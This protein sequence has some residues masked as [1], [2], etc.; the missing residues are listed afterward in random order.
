MKYY[1]NEYM[2]YYADEY[3]EGSVLIWPHPWPLLLLPYPN[4]VFFDMQCG[5]LACYQRH[6]EGFYLPVFGQ[7]GQAFAHSL[8][9]LHPGCNGP[10]VTEEQAGALDAIF[11]EF[12]VPLKVVRSRLDYSYEAWVHVEVLAPNEDWLLSN[13]EGYEGILIWRNC[14]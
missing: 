2:A 1:L 8:E 3:I 6:I 11:A 12:Q 7:Y 5:G 14:D 9:A 13:F 4:G 10:S